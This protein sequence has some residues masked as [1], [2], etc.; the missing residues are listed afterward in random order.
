MARKNTETPKDETVSTPCTEPESTEQAST[1]TVDVNGIDTE[2]SEEQVQ[3]D[4]SSTDESENPE[5]V[6]D[7]PETQTPPETVEKPALA[8]PTKKMQYVSFFEQ[9]LEFIGS[10]RPEFAIKALNNCVKTM[11]AANTQEAINDVF[12]LFKKNKSFLNPNVALQAIA[13]LPAS[14]RAAVEIIITV[15]S[16]IFE[17]KKNDKSINLDMV[18][19]IIKSETFINWC[20][21]KLS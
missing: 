17:G 21:K 4:T 11:L 2:S 19:K 13:T 3:G 8:I 10:K 16:I 20:V 18:R 15:F 9:Y 5:D 12:G 7:N 14:D 1:E 6:Q